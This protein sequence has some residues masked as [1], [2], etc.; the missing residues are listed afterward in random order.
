M[1]DHQHVGQRAVLERGEHVLQLGL[2]LRG[3][4]VRAGD[5]VQ[6]ERRGPR[7]QRLQRGAKVFAHL[8]IGEARDFGLAG[9]ARGVRLVE[10]LP[11]LAALHD[12]RT[13]FAVGAGQ[14]H[15]HACIKQEDFFVHQGAGNPMKQA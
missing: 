8:G 14:R 7:R 12:Y 6:H 10:D 5:E 4:L 11:G 13:Y 9:A 2:R 1:A 3:E 15:A